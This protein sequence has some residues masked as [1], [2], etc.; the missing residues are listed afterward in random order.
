MIYVKRFI[1]GVFIGVSNVIPGISGG[2]MAVVFNLY[3]Q[4]IEALS[5]NIKSIKKNFWF[6][7]TIACGIVFGILVF[8]HIMNYFLENY[9]NQTYGAFIG[10]VMGSIP[11][12]I[13]KGNIH[14]ANI[15]NIISFLLFFGIMIIM[16]L[17]QEQQASMVSVEQLTLPLTI[18]LFFAA[19]IATITML[20]PGV[21]G[22]LLLVMIGYYHAIYTFTIRQLVFPQLIVVVVGMLFGLLAGAKLVSYFLKKFKDIIY[23]GILGLII[24][25]L[26]PLFPSLDQPISTLVSLV[27]AAMLIYYFNKMNHH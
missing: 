12:I 2:T 8:S 9:E 3:D 4:L 24:G 26:F 15:P 10:V 18:G 14:Q 11:I 17:L 22:S 20:I 27:V 19:S 6:L 7:A 13:K 1:G 16:W 21:S 5:L 23:A 25:S